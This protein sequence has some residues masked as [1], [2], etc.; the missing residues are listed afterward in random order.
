MKLLT[1]NM[2]DV[3]REQM[4]AVVQAD[5]LPYHVPTRATFDAWF[6]DPALRTFGFIDPKGF[7]LGCSPEDRDKTYLTFIAVDP[8]QR[9]QGNG[10]R[11]LETFLEAAP[12][13][14]VECVFF[15]PMHLVWTLPGTKATH[16]NAPGVAVD[17]AAEKF[18]KAKGFESF[19]TQL[20]YYL[21]LKTYVKPTWLKDLESEQ[22]QAGLTVGFFDPNKYRGITEFFALIGNPDWEK[23]FKQ[24]AEAAWPRP[25]LVAIDTRDNRVIGFT[26]PLTRGEDGRGIFSGIAVHPDY[27]GRGLAKTLFHHLIQGFQ[28]IEAEYMTLFTGVNN[29]GRRIYEK[30]GFQHVKTWTDLR[31]EIAK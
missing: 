9:R 5:A 3:L 7:I 8:E 19:A 26:G 2:I 23:E 21:D 22:Q 16:P 11:L 4:A 1:A 10:S 20:S 18:L 14:V 17:T 28:M 6:A 13:P 29:P 27:R 25:L 15:N 12:E 31:K 24:E 30:A